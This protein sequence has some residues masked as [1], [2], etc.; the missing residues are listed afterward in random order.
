MSVN[1][2]KQKVYIESDFFL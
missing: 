2:Y 1:V